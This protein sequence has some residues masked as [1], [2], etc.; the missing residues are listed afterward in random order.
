MRAS[1]TCCE[2]T[3]TSCAKGCASTRKSRLS[4][5]ARDPTR[6]AAET[7]AALRDFHLAYVAVGSIASDQMRR[8]LR[9]MS[10]LTPEADKRGDVSPGLLCANRVVTGCRGEAPLFDSLSALPV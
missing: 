2:I 6:G 8:W 3:S 4:D 10:A 5:R 9:P 7:A 1:S